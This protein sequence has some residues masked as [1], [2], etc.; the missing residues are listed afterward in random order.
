MSRPPGGASFAQFF[1]SAPRAAKD[2]ATE[3][4]RAKSRVQE[5]SPTQAA[6]AN[7]ATAATTNGHLSP[8][9]SSATQHADE[10]PG[11]GLTSRTG[12]DG[13]VS[14]ATHLQSDDVES[15]PGDTLNAVGSA[16]SHAS[17][18]SSVLSSST[19]QSAIVTSKN[20]SHLT[21]LTTFDSPSSSG[22]AMPL[23]A[24]AK[25]TTPQLIDKMNETASKPNGNSAR[26]SPAL[27]TGAVERK[28][29]RDPNRSV[30]GVKCVYKSILDRSAPAAS[31][32]KSKPI[33]QEFG[34]V[35]TPTIYCSLAREERHLCES[36]G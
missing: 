25:S 24:K 20:S 28:P 15:L 13:S 26:P 23:P 8:L 29:A 33:F 1:P 18:A 35:C 14:D 7:A 27:L 17:T 30:K 9:A 11:P 32:A 34:L 12:R 6:T 21:P 16:S 19:R 36:Y 22:N 10:A 4:E 2:R 31:S 5:S 3:R